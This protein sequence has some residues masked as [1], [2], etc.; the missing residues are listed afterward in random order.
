MTV[1]K[2]ETALLTLYFNNTDHANIGDAAGLQHSAAAGSFYLSLHTADPGETG[3]QTTSET[4]Y[5]SYARQAV[6]RSSAGFT[7]SGNAVQLVIDRLCQ[8][9]APVT[10]LEG[11]CFSNPAIGGGT[12]KAGGVVF[13]G[14]TTVYYRVTVRVSGPRNTSS[15]VQAILSR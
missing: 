11:K 8:G 14:A 2:F 3:D 4:T 15:T 13:S 1:A 7:V 12:K 6:A 5:G 10:D 9:P